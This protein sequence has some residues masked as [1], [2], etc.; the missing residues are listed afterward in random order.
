MLQ[1]QREVPSSPPLV[2]SVASAST[3]S[4]VMSD[5]SSLHHKN[6]IGLI[7][8]YFDE[9][10]KFVGKALESDEKG[11]RLP[12]LELYNKA[13]KSAQSGLV[14]IQESREVTSAMKE[15][16]K[17]LEKLKGQVK[18]RMESLLEKEEEKQLSRSLP[19]TQTHTSRPTD[20]VSS[21]MG[22]KSVSG[23]GRNNKDT[24]GGAE[25]EI[26]FSSSSGCKVIRVNESGCVLNCTPSEAMHIF[27]YKEHIPGQPPA[28]IQ[29]GDFVY[30]LVPGQ[31]PVLRSSQF[32]YVFPDIENNGHTVGIVFS[33]GL[34]KNE[35]REL[36]QTLK[37]LSDFK[38]S[39]S[40]GA[41]AGDSKPE[42]EDTPTWGGSISEKIESGVSW[43]SGVISTGTN[44][45]GE[46]LNKGGDKLRDNIEP[47]EQPV[48]I[49]QSVE[50]GA[51]YARRA[52]GAVVGVSDF[53]M[54]TLAKGTVAVGKKIG[55]AVADSDMVK[56][57]EIN[58]HA[59]EAW[60][61]TKS[62]AKGAGKVFTD[63]EQGAK[64]IIKGAGTE[65]S[66]TVGHKY[67]DQAG[68]VSDDGL[69]AAGNTVDLVSTYWSWKTWGIRFLGKVG[70]VIS[71]QE[72]EKE[73]EVSH[74]QYDSGAE[75]QQQVTSRT[76]DPVSSTSTSTPPL[77]VNKHKNKPIKEV[78]YS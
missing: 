15:I 44:K 68:R 78:L 26:V 37:V 22:M 5:M 50:K 72:E 39:E 11:E 75:E 57:R 58:P 55:S 25:A 41:A 64:A 24:L 14:I 45:A 49:P 40:S 76:L 28:F 4:S 7:Q 8:D 6:K 20:S 21:S 38:V 47:R 13:L 42:L 61:V 53:L 34:T 33:G 35:I 71:T 43:V 17:K 19:K 29:C 27:R 54:V 69:A 48:E 56:G 36:N 12:A 3:T 32:A 73:R 46:L 67:G 31:S 30:P 1:E 63:L 59:K 66:K 2:S 52:T 9:A 51:Y 16:K 74:H 70:K 23:G 60:K 62:T 10:K 65:T 18:S 77:S